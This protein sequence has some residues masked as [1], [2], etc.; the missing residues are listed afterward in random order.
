MLKGMYLSALII[1]VDA[2]LPTEQ[3]YYLSYIPAVAL[4]ETVSV[5]GIFDDKRT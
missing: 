3:I 1:H 2:P 5:A 4:R